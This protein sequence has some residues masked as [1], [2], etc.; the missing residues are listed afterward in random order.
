MI[1]VY[2][3]DYKEEGS[4]GLTW[5]KMQLIFRKNTQNVK[6][7]SMSENSYLLKKLVIRGS[8]IYILQLMLLP[9]NRTDALKVQKKSVRFFVEDGL[10]FIKGI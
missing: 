5:N 1:L 4:T 6:S 8:L 7:L 2:I 10:L 9:S 3:D